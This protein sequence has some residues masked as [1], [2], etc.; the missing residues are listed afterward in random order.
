MKADS[1]VFTGMQRPLT[2]L[3]LPP[4]LL[5]GTACGAGMIM[6]FFVYLGLLPLA[7][8]AFIL[9]FAWMWWKLW[10]RKQAD[11]HFGS[12]LFAALRFWGR[13]GRWSAKRSRMV[14]GLPYPA[15]NRRQAGL[16][17]AKIGQAACWERGCQYV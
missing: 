2:M 3:G 11:S 14:A 5:I 16:S 4:A 8:P 12:V 9:S 17:T 10:R 7:L 6:L 13:N 15:R 1:V